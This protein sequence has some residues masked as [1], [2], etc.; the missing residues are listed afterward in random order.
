MKIGFVN[1]TKYNVHIVFKKEN[2]DILL[3]PGKRTQVSYENKDVT[4]VHGM[5]LQQA[6][7]KGIVSVIH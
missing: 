3:S 6:V 1:R 5:T 2:A 7:A 4:S